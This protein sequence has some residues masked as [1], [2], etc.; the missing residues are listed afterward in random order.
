MQSSLRGNASGVYQAVQNN[1]GPTNPQQSD[2][3]ADHATD[4]MGNGNGSSNAGSWSMPSTTLSLSRADSEVTLH[5]NIATPVPG[6]PRTD[7][8]D[9]LPGNAPGTVGYEEAYNCL[10]RATGRRARMRILR[11]V[12][13]GY[14][15]LSEAD[16]DELIDLIFQRILERDEEADM[17]EQHSDHI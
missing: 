16:K 4:R 12:R 3:E 1:N 5:F 2:S 13:N 10:R 17:E 8:T 9:T 7:T 11:D 15:I 6:S 14:F